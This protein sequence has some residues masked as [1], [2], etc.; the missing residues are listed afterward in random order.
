[1]PALLEP[2]GRVSAGALADF[3][4][5]NRAWSKARLLEHGALLFR[6]FGVRSPAELE[7]IAR[8][9]D[10]ELKNEYLGTSPRDALTDYVFSASELPGYYPIP[11][12]CEMTFTK[13]P[14][15]RIFFWCDVASATGG[16]TPLV[17]F[18]RVLNDLDADVRRRFEQG[19]IR[20]IR[21]Y[22]GPGKKKGDLLQLKRWDEMFL[23]TDKD[24]V[25]ARARAEGFEPSWH[26]DRLTLTSEH[27]AVRTH[28]DTG[29]PVWFNHA[30][31]FHLSTGSAELGRIFRHRP[32][33]R[34]LGFWALAAVLSARKRTLPA[35]EQALHCT[36]RDGREIAR[37]DLDHVRDVIW[38]NLVVYPWQAGDVV[39]IDNSAVGHGRLP[40][41]GPR[42]IA[43][44]WA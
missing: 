21:N 29:E 41:R 38:Q 9:I 1:L 25:T 19:G 31:V 30:Q 34:V 18:R 42:R 24:A 15:R 33:L 13:T 8:A 35:S 5:S 14:P 36:H 40:Y 16:E 17:D 12:H 11:Q 44:C 37:R 28:P 32:S 22:V 2:E 7:K 20:V 23:T 43:V 4:E 39:A 27:D 26:G 6:G 3:L 10:P